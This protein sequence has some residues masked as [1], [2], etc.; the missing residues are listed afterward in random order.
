MALAGAGLSNEE[1]ATRLFVSPATARTHVSR[2]MVKLGA[3]D[4]AQL[5]VL[6]YEAGLVRPGWS[7]DPRSG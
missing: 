5:V 2:A 7:A 1:I 4:R 6:A 3:R